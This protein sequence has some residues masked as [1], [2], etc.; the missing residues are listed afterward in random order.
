M[1]NKLKTF[2]SSSREI[3]NRITLILYR[4]ID[5]DQG[6]LGY[7]SCKT[8]EL[9]CYTLE[10]PDHDNLPNISRIP[11]G[12]YD[13]DYLKRSWSGKYHNTYHVRK[14]PG[15]SGILFHKGNWAKNSRGC[16]LTGLRPSKLCG[17]MSVS[18]SAAALNQLR[19]WIG[20]RGFKLEIRDCAEST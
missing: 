11:A 19:N 4:I 14:V 16:I 18:D 10:L 13:V 3:D 7:L 9:I 20:K 12:H 2:I 5:H 15:R 6:T 1:I 8:G 17:M